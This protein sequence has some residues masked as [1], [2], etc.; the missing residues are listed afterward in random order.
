MAGITTEQGDQQ[1]QDR[2]EGLLDRGN[3]DLDARPVVKNKDG[4]ISTVRSMS[5]GIAAKRF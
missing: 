1:Q 4:T 5:V 3:I 2:P